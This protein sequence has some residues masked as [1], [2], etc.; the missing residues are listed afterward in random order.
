MLPTAECDAHAT[1]A[2]E[3]L[4]REQRGP[5]VAY[6]GRLVDDHCAAED[7]CHEAFLKA[8]RGWGQCGQIVN[9][10]AWLYRI[11]TNTAYDYLRRRRLIHFAPLD[12]TTQPP[13]GAD[14]IESRL[15]EQEPIQHVLALLSPQA[16]RLLLYAYAGHTTQEIAAALDCSDTAV[17]LRLF[18]ARERFRKVY[19]ALGDQ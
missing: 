8:L 15:H 13:G 14:S 9:V 4:Y 6:L 18:R 2:I 17:R 19:S 11:A 10:S 16:R 7:L 12:E 1:A 5:L 3:A